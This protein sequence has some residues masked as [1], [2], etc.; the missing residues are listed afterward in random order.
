LT[1][2]GGRRNVLGVSSLASKGKNVDDL[3]SPRHLGPS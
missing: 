1:F 3:Q 2:S